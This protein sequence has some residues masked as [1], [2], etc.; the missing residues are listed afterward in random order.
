VAQKKLIFFF[1]LLSLTG[2]PVQSAFAE[3]LNCTSLFEGGRPPL[4]SSIGFSYFKSPVSVDSRIATSVSPYLVPG[5]DI[6]IVNSSSSA[7]TQKLKAFCGSCFK[8]FQN[9]WRAVSSEETQKLDIEGVVPAGSG[10][11]VQIKT[12]PLSLR[13]PVREFTPYSGIQMSLDFKGSSSLET[14][15]SLVLNA[16]RLK[17]GSDS[18]YEY[19]SFKE[20]LSKAQRVFKNRN[21]HSYLIDFAQ[22][23][24]TSGLK[25]SFA[26]LIVE[27]EIISYGFEFTSEASVDTP[28]KMSVVG[29]LYFVS[30]LEKLMARNRLRL[31]HLSPEE[32]EN[33]FLKEIPYLD[34]GQ[35][36]QILET[37]RSRDANWAAEIS[38]ERKRTFSYP[39]GQ[40]ILEKFFNENKALLSR[41]TQNELI[42]LFQER[43]VVVVD[44]APTTNRGLSSHSFWTP[45]P[46]FLAHFVARLYSHDRQMNTLR[47]LDQLGLDFIIQK[48]EAAG[49]RPEQ[50]EV[51]SLATLWEKVTR[52]RIEDGDNWQFRV[53]TDGGSFGEDHGEISHILQFFTIIDGMND[54][55]IRDFKSIFMHMRT[56]SSD[57]IY[58]WPLLFDGGGSATP[59]APRYWR[60]LVAKYRAGAI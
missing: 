16:R 9:R 17:K 48:L 44:R 45:P 36:I 59:N 32:L 6:Q 51:V 60:D 40:R 24:S 4:N 35:L 7:W 43:P 2:I 54:Q 50:L 25:Q 26:D 11:Q 53:V 22:L 52:R 46:H 34:K 56:S 39:D 38:P 37:V 8:G 3:G 5:D 12:Q 21:E 41:L 33:E 49:F 1:M 15:T 30:D 27:V 47:V 14:Q 19:L 58:L 20:N 28:V 23:K 31:A 13:F 29:D 57:F 42:S 18:E 55:E 10:R